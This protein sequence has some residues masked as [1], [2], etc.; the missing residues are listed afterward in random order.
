[1]RAPGA[2]RHPRSPVIGEAFFQWF[3]DQVK[4]SKGRISSNMLLSMA[5]VLAG[6]L[7]AHLE[8]TAPSSSESK[9]SAEQ[10]PKQ[11]WSWLLRWRREYGVA[12]ARST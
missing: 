6:Y 4:T 2:G 8:D 9:S 3:V 1:M 12:P 10:V 7:K 11:D 5:E